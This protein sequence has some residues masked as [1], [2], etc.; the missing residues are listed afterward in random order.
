MDAGQN[1][2]D[3]IGPPPEQE[4]LTNI[5][6]LV[7]TLTQQGASIASEVWKDKGYSGLSIGDITAMSVSRITTQGE[8]QHPD[9][10]VVVIRVFK[11]KAEGRAETDYTV[12]RENGNL[13]I[14]KHDTVR[15]EEDE[16]EHR[17]WKEKYKQEGFSPAKAME[18]IEEIKSKYEKNKENREFE[19][20][21]G[22]SY[23]DRDET[24]AVIDNLTHLQGLA[25]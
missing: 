11:K 22:F 24:Q 23:V 6:T 21:I 25:A 9:F 16:Q 7:D 20:T 19:K 14:D 8:Q 13:R 12:S 15:T 10:P 17:Q 2:L 3:K 5:V 1:E 18:A 4:Q